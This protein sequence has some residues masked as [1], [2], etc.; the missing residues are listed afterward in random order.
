MGAMMHK[1][2]QV[3]D[4]R[5]WLVPVISSLFLIAVSFY[6]YLTFHLL[7]ELVA[8][9][10]SMVMFAVAWFTYD[11]SKNHGWAFLAGGYFWIGILD[12]V[13]SLA[14]KDMNLMVRDKG[15]I[16]TQIWIVTRYLEAV[17]LFTVV[18]F[19]YHKRS[20]MLPI[21]GMGIITALALGSIFLGIFPD[22]FIE[23]EGLTNFKIISEYIIVA[24]LIIT[25]ITVLR[26]RETLS[27][28][29]VYYL[30]ISIIFTVIAELAFTFYVSV[31]GLSNLIGHLAKVFSYW[32]LFLLIVE[33]GLRKPY[34][35]LHQARDEAKAA[36]DAKSMFLA[37]MS[38]DLRTPLNA[39]I[40][41]S[42][43]MLEKTFG[44]IGNKHYKDYISYI[45]GSGTQ[46]LSLINDI[47]DLSKIESGEYQLIEESV[48][49][50]EVN[51]ILQQSHQIEVHS[52]NLTCDFSIDASLQGLTADHRA[53]WQIANNLFANAVKYT[54]EGGEISLRWSYVPG[55]AV[56]LEV[57]DTGCGI[58]EADVDLVMKPF[59][60]G[61][62]AQLSRAHSGTGLG[63]YIC[64]RLLDIHG[65]RLI[66]D[67]VLGKGTTIR[68]AFPE[69]RAI[70]RKA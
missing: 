68:G 69:E 3:L 70:L 54:N 59:Y 7:A 66:I 28:N 16:S 4:Y 27:H 26:H 12:L 19:K 67:S 45:H 65:G 63:L 35:E 33:E 9:I 49:L 34:Y 31:F 15:N 20:P 46:L 39:I 51:Q 13:H 40:G 11:L 17:L 36:N 62:D 1:D 6:N 8:I 21:I 24:I 2:K 25:A 56:Y 10:I 53:I 50:D 48:D 57:S 61:E 38:H 29:I 41:F 55:E 14:Y 60:R 47:L 30:L 44:P 22:A 64:R 32:A 43:V 18:N 23:G 5:L 42:E 37:S 52:K 58:S